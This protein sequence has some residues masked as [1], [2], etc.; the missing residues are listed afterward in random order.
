MFDKYKS[1]ILVVMKNYFLNMKI[2]SW[3]MKIFIFSLLF[4]VD[5]YKKS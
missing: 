1:S 4:K 2:Q 5:S 3:K